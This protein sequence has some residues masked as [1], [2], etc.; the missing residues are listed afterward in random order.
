MVASSDD[1]DMIPPMHMYD[2]KIVWGFLRTKDY[3]QIFNLREK[4]QYAEI[5]ATGRQICLVLILVIHRPLWW[6]FK[7]FKVD[8]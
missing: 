3:S 2:M 8:Y 7:N 5:E 4:G 6:S 1:K